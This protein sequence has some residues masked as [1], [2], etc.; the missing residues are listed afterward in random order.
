MLDASA[1][2]ERLAALVQPDGGWGYKPGQA[3]HLEPTCLALLALSAEPEKY[4]SIIANGFRALEAC[5][6]ADGSYRLP[7]GR[8]QA[9]WMTALVLFTRQILQHELQSLRATIAFLLAVE[10]RVVKADAEV[11]DVQDIDLGLVGWPWAEANFSWVEPTCWACI[12]LRSVGE[13]HHPR[14]HEGMK[15]L[16]DRAFDTGGV[17][18][19]SGSIPIAA[20]RSE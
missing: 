6:Q 3:M 9:V 1:V 15:L 8:P 19:G 17:N 13:G 18:V 16:L 14:V 4:S 2:R 7:R 10:G 5:R 20:R 11:A 12:A